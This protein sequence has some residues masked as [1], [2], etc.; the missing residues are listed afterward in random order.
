MAN[1]DTLSII[2]VLHFPTTKDAE[3]AEWLLE[4]NRV[5]LRNKTGWPVYGGPSKGRIVAI[6]VAEQEREFLFQTLEA[7]GMTYTRLSQSPVPS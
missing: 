4:L 3:D 7:G 1:S 6:E 2:V 5:R